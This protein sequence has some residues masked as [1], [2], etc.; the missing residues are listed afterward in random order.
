M[1]DKA[2]IRT[3]MRNTSNMSNLKFKGSNPA[4]SRCR[5]GDSKLREFWVG[6]SE[7]MAM[8]ST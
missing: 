5:Q 1:M 4:L 2:S 3:R 7:K 8:Y 6:G